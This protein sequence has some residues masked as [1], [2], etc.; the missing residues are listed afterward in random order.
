MKQR[1]D[2]RASTCVVC[3]SETRCG[4][5][6]HRTT[7]AKEKCPD[8]ERVRRRSDDDD[9][10]AERAIAMDG[11]GEIR[12]ATWVEIGTECNQISHLVE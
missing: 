2:E 3:T 5:F 8:R 11:C 12:D 10:D 9:D 7:R 6:R 4:F 1:A